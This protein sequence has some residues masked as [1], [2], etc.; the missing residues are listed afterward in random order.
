MTI[1]LILTGI[2]VVVVLTVRHHLRL[3]IGRGRGT[4][5]HRD[6]M[7]VDGG[8]TAGGPGGGHSHVVRVTRDPHRYARAFVP[9]R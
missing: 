2:A 5:P 8:W 6:D 9:R 7:I 4:L 3:E 1:A